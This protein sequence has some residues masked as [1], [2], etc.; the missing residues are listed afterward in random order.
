MTPDKA[1]GI[2]G[3]GLQLEKRDTGPGNQNVTETDAKPEAGGA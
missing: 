2:G 1:V 3:A